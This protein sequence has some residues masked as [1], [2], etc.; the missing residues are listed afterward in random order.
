VVS[1]ELALEEAVERLE[2]LGW[3]REAAEARAAEAEARAARERAAAAAA[4]PPPS[5]S[6]SQPQ[7]P[8]R[9]RRPP[10]SGAGAGEAARARAKAAELEEALRSSLDALGIRDSQSVTLRASLRSARAEREE[11]RGALEAARLLAAAQSARL[12]LLHRILGYCLAA[13]VLLLVYVLW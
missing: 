12:Q 2:T 6:P 1:L 4:P 3:E 5:P 7:P 10:S 8:P 11:A 9:R 13:L